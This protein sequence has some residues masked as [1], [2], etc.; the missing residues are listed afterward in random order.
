MLSK[1]T[2]TK[3]IG[4]KKIMICKNFEFFVVLNL[5]LFLEDD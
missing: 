5:V 1:L 2:I 4:E 3:D